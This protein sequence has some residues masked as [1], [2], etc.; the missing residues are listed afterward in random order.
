[1]S[2]MIQAKCLE[3]KQS[4]KSFDWVEKSFHD[5]C[6]L[7]LPLKNSNRTSYGGAK[8]EP[9]F[10]ALE[11]TSNILDSPILPDEIVLFLQRWSLNIV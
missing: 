7:S 8:I 6:K 5:K 1:M 4:T 3:T 9:S 2:E 10:V 11:L